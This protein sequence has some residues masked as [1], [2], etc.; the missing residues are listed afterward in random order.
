LAEPDVDELITLLFQTLSGL[1]RQQRREA[2]AGLGPS[3]HMLLW[4]LKPRGRFE[5]PWPQGPSRVSDL[6]Q[7]LQLTPAA[8]TQL[9]ADLERRGYVRRDRDERDRRAV[10]VSLTQ[11]GEE[12][13]AEHRQRRRSEMQRLV[14]ALDPQDRQALVRILHRIREMNRRGGETDH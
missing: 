13:L 10:V 11:A 8:I 7:A 5:A 6:A 3:H 14:E 2:E 1:R 12:V 4:R 9:V